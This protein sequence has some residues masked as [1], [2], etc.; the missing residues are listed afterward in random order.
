MHPEDNSCFTIMSQRDY[1]ATLMLA[2]LVANPECV[3]QPI[4]LLVNQAVRLA[5]ELGSRLAQP[6]PEP[7][8][9]GQRVAESLQAQLDQAPAAPAAPTV[10]RNWCGGPLRAPIP[11][12]VPNN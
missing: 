10:A 2:S 5:D 11:G 12:L 6:V 1:R 7:D 3:Y 8:T 9:I 4:E